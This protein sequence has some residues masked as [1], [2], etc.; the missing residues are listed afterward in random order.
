ME[1]AKVKEG[2]VV[3]INKK[4]RIFIAEITEKSRGQVNF[5]ALSPNIS[6]T[7]ATAREVIGH[8]TKD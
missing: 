4:G 5:K 1:L 3:K 2:D 6:Y 7:T 8:Y